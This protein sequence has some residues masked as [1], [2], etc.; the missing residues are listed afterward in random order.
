MLQHR[1][2]KHLSFDSL[3]KLEP[4]LMNKMDRHKLFCD[5]CELRK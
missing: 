5:A 3:S 2:L 4:E 1:R